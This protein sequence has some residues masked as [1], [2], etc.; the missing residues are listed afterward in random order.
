MFPC[1]FCYSSPGRVPFHLLRF[2]EVQPRFHLDARKHFLTVRTPRVWNGLPREVVE[3]PLVLVFKD[4][5]D[6]HMVG[7]LAVSIPRLDIVIALVGAIS[8]STLALILPPLVEIFTYYKEKQSSWIIL[9]D[10]SITSFGVIGFLTGTYVTIQEIICPAALISVN[11]TGMTD[12]FN[13][14]SHPT[15]GAN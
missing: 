8:S 4:R 6:M 2:S 13:T 10:I 12:C 5:L 7:A 15:M 3:A 14:T 1:Y 11:A 9:K